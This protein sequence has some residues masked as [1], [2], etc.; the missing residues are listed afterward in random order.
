M[1]ARLTEAMDRAEKKYRITFY[2]SGNFTVCLIRT[3][4][5]FHQAIVSW[6]VSKCNPNC[7]EYDID[8]GEE[9]AFERAVK[10]L[11]NGT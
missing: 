1:N 7:D 5:W 6:G 9:I 3:K 8:C 4:G 10:R 2:P 11:M